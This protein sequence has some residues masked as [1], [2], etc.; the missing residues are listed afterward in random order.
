MRTYNGAGER[1]N[2]RYGMVRTYNGMGGG[3]DIQRFWGV[4]EVGGGTCN[5]WGWGEDMQRY[6]WGVGGG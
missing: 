4:G 6:G 2:G 1:Y 3:G 5:V